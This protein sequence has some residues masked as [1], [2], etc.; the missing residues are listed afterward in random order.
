MLS[1]IICVAPQYRLISTLLRSL[2]PRRELASVHNSLGI[3]NWQ[4]ARSASKLTNPTDVLSFNARGTISALVF[5]SR[6]SRTQ[7]TFSSR[8][9]RTLPPTTRGEVA[10]DGEA[11]L[12]VDGV[13]VDVEAQATHSDKRVKSEGPDVREV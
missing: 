9:S 3:S 7:P 1:I 8:L 4:I 12:E 13:S 11:V 6:F 10:E 5:S 2:V